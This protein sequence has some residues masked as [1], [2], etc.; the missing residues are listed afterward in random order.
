MQRLSLNDAV[1]F[2]VN[3]EKSGIDF[4]QDC[5]QKAKKEYSRNVFLFL[6]NEEKKHLEVL[7]R[8]FQAVEERG[9]ATISG[10][11]AKMLLD[12]YAKAFFPGEAMVGDKPLKKLNVVESID[13]AIKIELN[14]I[15]YYKKL[16]S[17]LSEEHAG[18]MDKI[19]AEENEHYERFKRL[20]SSLV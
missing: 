7:K 2:A 15:N 10:K 8:M 19:L 20:K 1:D 3:L 16:K 17:V 4:Y 12:A 9:D 6:A 11:R 13:F 14:T 5:S 18:A